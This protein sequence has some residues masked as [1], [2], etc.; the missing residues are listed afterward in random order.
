MKGEITTSQQQ[1]TELP[2]AL[3]NIENRRQEA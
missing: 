1:I 3:L 2:T